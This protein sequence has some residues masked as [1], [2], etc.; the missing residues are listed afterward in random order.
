MNIIV[1]IVNFGSTSPAR[2]GNQNLQQNNGMMADNHIHSKPTA[3][4][5]TTTYKGTKAM[6]CKIHIWNTLINTLQLLH[7]IK[8]VSLC[9][10]SITKKDILDSLSS[11]IQKTYLATWSKHVCSTITYII[12]SSLS[13][14]WDTWNRPSL[15]HYHYRQRA[16]PH[17]CCP[18]TNR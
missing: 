7:I 14:G 4:W 5:P 17:L 15:K 13:R 18:R 3:R 2:W 9:L 8:N 1:S 12:V 11:N 6:W 16:Q 10:P